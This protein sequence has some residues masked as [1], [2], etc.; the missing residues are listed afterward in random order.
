MIK[1]AKYFKRLKYKYKRKKVS[2]ISF[3]SPQITNWRNKKCTE[4]WR[5]QKRTGEKSEIIYSSVAFGGIFSSVERVSYFFE[6][7][8]DRKM[9]QE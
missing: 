3:S 6:I 9:R 5:I 2:I 1:F 4:K 8:R 7:G